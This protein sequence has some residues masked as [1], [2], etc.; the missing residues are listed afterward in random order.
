[1]S[2]ITYQ[3]KYKAVDLQKTKPH[4]LYTSQLFLHNLT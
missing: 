4:S 3:V 2:F 1:M